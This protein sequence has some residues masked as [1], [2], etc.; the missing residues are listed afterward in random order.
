MKSY[1]Y[2]FRKS[3][4]YN[5]GSTDNLE[6]AKQLLIPDEVIAVL[7]SN[8]SERLRRKLH[9]KYQNNRLPQSDYFKLTKVQRDNCKESLINAGGEKD[10][11]PFFSGFKL[12]IFFITCW[13]GI[14]LLIIR[15]LVEPALNKLI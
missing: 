12:F 15:V 9:L 2:L 13:L 6:Q 5:I 4:L 3:E 10:I 1:V 8:D 14:S 7:L 11:K